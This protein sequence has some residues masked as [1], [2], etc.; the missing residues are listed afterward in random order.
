M[1][2]SLAIC[3]RFRSFC[4]ALLALGSALY[5]GSCNSGYSS[6]PDTTPPTA[7]GNLSATVISPTQINLTWTAST[8]YVGVTGYRVERCSSAGCSN[9]AQI[10]TPTATTYNDTGLNSSTSYSYRVRATDAAGNL[11]KDRKSVV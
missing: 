3:N 10:A 7:P 6:P 4:A 8:D 1:K 9:F 5:T 11:S 2:C